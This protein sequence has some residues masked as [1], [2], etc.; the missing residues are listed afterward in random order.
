MLIIIAVTLFII[1]TGTVTAQQR[2]LPSGYKISC[3]FLPEHANYSVYTVPNNSFMRG[4]AIV[5]FP[6]DISGD[7]VFYLHGELWIDSILVRNDKIEYNYESVFCNRDYSSVCIRVCIENSANLKTD[8]IEIHYS[9]Y[10]HPS[11]ARSISNYMRVTR[12]DG[13][14]LRSFGYSIWFPV[15]E[16]ESL[17]NYKSEFS[18]VKITTPVDYKTVVCGNLKEDHVVGN[19]RVAVWEPGFIDIGEVQCV[20]RKYEVLEN[21]DVAVYFLKGND[22]LR[23]ANSILEYSGRLKNLFYTNLRKVESG[24]KVIVCEMPKYGD[25]SSANVIGL[26][27]ERFRSFDSEIWSKSTLAHEMLHPYVHIPVD[28]DNPFYSLIIEGF[29]SFMQVYAMARMEP[30]SFDI[31]E[32]SQN[33][34]QGYINKR[35][36][37]KTARGFELPEEK[38]ILEITAEEIGTY[39]DK[40][41]LA[42]RVWLLMIWLWNEMGDNNYDSFLGELFNMNSIDYDLF[43]KLVLKYIP[44]SKEDLRIWLK[45]TDYPKRFYPGNQVANF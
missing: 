29:P 13:V 35:E 22:S 43:E 23:Y 42:D 8:N 25:I 7:I 40:F 28:K 14:L 15:F 34:H 20:S 6:G 30:E 38:P 11:K 12:E 27:D 21:D 37:G 4:Q 17:D 41:V 44:G 18:E 36:T 45:T 33:Y 16:G 32:A 5:Y 39:K 31:K 24:S 26:A 9:G 10:L 3:E 19:R 2:Q 1:E